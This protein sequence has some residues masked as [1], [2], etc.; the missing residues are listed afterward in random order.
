MSL[1]NWEELNAKA[2]TYHQ[3][4]W[5]SEA[6]S[7]G[8]DALKLAEEI[9]GPDHLN[10]AESLKNLALICFAQAQD[11]EAAIF[12]Q[13]LAARDKM[14]PQ[15][16]SLE[17]EQSLNRVVLLNLSK[18]KYYRAESLMNR[19]L[20]IRKEALGQDHPDVLESI[21]NLAALYNTQGRNAEAK[22]LLRSVRSR[23]AMASISIGMAE[24]EGSSKGF[25]EGY[26]SRRDMR[27]SCHFPVRISKE[28]LDTAIRGVTENLSQ[29]GTFIKTKDLSAFKIN[30]EVGIH[31]FIPSLFSPKYKTVGMQGKGFITRVDEE[32]QGLA[33][34]FK[35]NFKT[36]GRIG[37]VEVP[38]KVRYKRVVDYMAA[39]EDR[40][41]V[42]FLEEHPQGFLLE[43]AEMTLE[44]GVIF[45]LRT[46]QLD[47]PE[48][49]SK[50]GGDAIPTSALQ[51]RV[52]EISKRKIDSN[53]GVIRIGRAANNDIV[54][55]N[56]L[57]SK[58]HAFMFFLSAE[59]DPYLVDLGSANGT[60]LNDEKMVLYE[61]HQ[62]KD[63]DQISF[64]PEIEVRY[65]STK[66]FY[67]FLHS[68][69]RP[70]ESAL[71]ESTD[72]ISDADR[73]KYPRAEISWPVTLKTTIVGVTRAQLGNLS[74]GGAYIHCD[75]TR[76]PGELIVLT[77]KPPDRQSLEIRAEVVWTGKTFPPGMGVRFLE[78]SENDCQFL[79]NVVL[80]HLKAESKEKRLALLQE[81]FRD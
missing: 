63:G 42:R 11:A 14:A 6:A 75:H 47:D 12:E 39:D 28:G 7:L 22:S 9:F 18:N 46:L 41:S 33:V 37:Q 38:E 29:I 44:E 1:Q 52:L 51:A 69:K 68:I 58:S 21:G 62:L 77:I 78:I 25:I 15:S 40:E 2:I 20:K 54:L 36:F 67:D 17:S 23:D 72:V 80:D 56:K 59:Q 66:A 50:I 65:L 45:Q 76:N 49:L 13:T 5:L 70:N 24:A 74:A 73:R 35:T 79:Y 16:D 3:Q 31:I 19:S 8:E 26:E 57:I 4:G 55:Y 64:G 10:T 27:H 53:H 32:N 48:V 43:K 61:M 71:I 81:G 30:D 34:Q 60:F